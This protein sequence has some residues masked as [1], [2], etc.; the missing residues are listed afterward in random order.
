MDFLIETPKINLKN[1]KGEVL[2]SIDPISVMEAKKLQ[3]LVSEIEEDD[4]QTQG[5]DFAIDMLTEKGIDRDFL[6]NKI[7]L[8]TLV[9]I[10]QFV[11]NPDSAKK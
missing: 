7:P 10:I 3:E 11:T 4:S 6:E 5:I 9:S 1:E 2:Y 8:N